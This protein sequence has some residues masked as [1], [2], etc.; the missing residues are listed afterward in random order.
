MEELIRSN[1][2][3]EGHSKGWHGVKCK[4]CNDYKPRA[5]FNFESEKIRYSCFNCGTS[6]SYLKNSTYMY[7]DFRQILNTYGISDSEIDMALGKSFFTK[8]QIILAKKKAESYIID[9]PLPEQS[10]QIVNVDE[11]DP[12]S[13]VAAEYLESR[14][15]TLTDHSW[16]LCNQESFRDRL[17]IPYYLDNRIIYWQARSFLEDAKKRYVNATSPI[18]PILFGYEELTKHTTAPLFIMEGVF[19]AISIGGVSML[20]SKLY[21]QRI[22]AFTKSRRRKIFVIDK[23]DK[24]NNGYK[25]GVDAVKHGWEITFVSGDTRDVNHAVTKYGKLWTIRNLIENAVGGFAAQVVLE[26]ICKNHS[27]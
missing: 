11:N 17:I 10:Y 14:G 18:E 5:G 3:F 2:H 19:D 8:D 7:H 9:T 12:W 27:T 13:M 26:T 22:E 21:K 15:L 20:G 24:Q 6:Q 25:L 4:C 16:F 1:V 23:K